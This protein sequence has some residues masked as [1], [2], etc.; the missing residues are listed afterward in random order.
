MSSDNPTLEAGVRDG[1]VAYEAAEMRGEFVTGQVAHDRWANLFTSN[2]AR[3]PDQRVGRRP[4]IPFD[5]N[6]ARPT[7]VPLVAEPTMSP[8]AG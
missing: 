4:A 5:A 2:Q 1:L 3:H 6:S 7:V 8:P